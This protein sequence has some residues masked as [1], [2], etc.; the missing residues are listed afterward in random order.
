MIYKIIAKVIANRLK[1]LLD[2]IISPS[3][4][5]LI[6]QRLTTDNII[7]G[8]ECL[9]QIRNKTKGNAGMVA[10]K[11]DVSKAYD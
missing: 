10:L 8:Y 5:A 11:L 7:V 1:P 2:H 4:S 9:H 3:Q 6:H